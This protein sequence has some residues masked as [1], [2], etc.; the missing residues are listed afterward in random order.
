MDPRFFYSVQAALLFLIISSPILYT[1]VQRVVG[2]F[3]TVAIKGCPT[4]AGLV[5]HSVVFALVTYLFMVLQE[6]KPAAPVVVVPPPPVDVKT[7]K[8]GFKNP[9]PNLNVLRK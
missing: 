6:P 7:E 4:V 5:L 1:F 9:K 8:E 2:R 3:F